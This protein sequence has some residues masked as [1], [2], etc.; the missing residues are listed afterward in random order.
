MLEGIKVI[1]MATYIAAP[2]PAASW[3]IG[4]PRL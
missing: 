4:V 1:E 3:Q 2:P